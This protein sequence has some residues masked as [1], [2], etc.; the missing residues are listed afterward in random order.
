MAASPLAR[1]FTASMEKLDRRLGWHRLPT[2][3]GLGVLLGIRMRLQEKNL[4]D[5]RASTNGHANGNGNGNG[6]VPKWNARYA[7]ARTADG[8]FNSLDDPL[9][10]SAGSRFGRNIPLEYTHPEVMP[11][12]MDPN[13]RTVSRELMTRDEFIPATRL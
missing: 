1:A 13:P 3:L 4:F 7:T 9:M 2:A 5:T 12:L 10:G 11:H 8:T 6:A